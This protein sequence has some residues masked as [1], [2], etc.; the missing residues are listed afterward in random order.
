[1]LKNEVGRPHITPYEDMCLRA[2]A[3]AHKATGAPITTHTDEAMLGLEQLALFASEG[4]DP[5]RVI[6]GHSGDTA[7]LAYH[8]SIMDQ[9]AYL[10][11]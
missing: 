6:V 5:K 3:R 10:G 1:M 9:G 2:A 7:N 8:T 4:V 11:V